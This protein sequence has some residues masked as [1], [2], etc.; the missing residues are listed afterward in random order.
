MIGKTRHRRSG[1]AAG[2]RSPR[3]RSGF[4]LLELLLA[5]S[6]LAVVTAVT[7]MTF[8]VV[9]KAWK[10]GSDLVDDLHHGDFVIDQLVMGLRSM[11]YSD[12]AVTPY[13][14][15]FQLQDNGDGPNESDKISWVAIGGALVGQSCP[16]ADAPHRI[17][18]SVVQDENGKPVAAVRAWRLYGQSED[19]DP[20]EDVEP[21]FLS[22][23]VVGFNCRPAYPFRKTTD[24]EIEWLDDWEYSNTVPTVVEVTLYLAPLDK[25]EEPIAVKRVVGIPVAAYALTKTGATIPMRPGT[26]TTGPGTPGTTTPGVTTPGV[27]TPGPA[28]PG[29]R[30]PGATPGGTGTPGG[31]SGTIG[32]GNTMVPVQPRPTGGGWGTP[33]GANR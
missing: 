31:R 19:F 13:E 25:G 20:E 16:F 23:R 27:T 21:V 32:P 17:E 10:R 18:F 29:R 33:G 11:Y 2:A 3:L 28:Y 7:F 14:Y 26:G 8:S 1:A 6:I 12:R 30:G 15:G 22:R 24:D 5:V 4:T 9:T